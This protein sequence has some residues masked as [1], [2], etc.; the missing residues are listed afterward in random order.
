MAVLQLNGISKAYAGE[1]ILNDITFSVDEKD[2]IGLIGL[3]GAGKTTIIKIILGEIEHDISQ[4]NKIKGNISFKSN[5]NIG[6]LSQNFDLNEENEIYTEMLHVFK[7]TLNIYER[8]KELNIEVS[9]ET[10]EVLDRKLKELAELSSRYEQAEGYSIEY[11]IKQVLIGLGI[12]E[13][14]YKK[15]IKNLSGGQKSRVSL[16]KI[17]L[18]EPDLLILDEPTNHLDIKAIEWLETFLKN[19]NK[20]FILISHDRYFLDNVINRVLEIEAKKIKSYSGNYTQFVIQKELIKRGEIKSF[21]KEQEKV[22]KMEEFIR[23]YK[24]GVKAKQARGRQKLLDRMDLMD[25]PDIKNQKIKLKFETDLLSTNNILTIENLSKQYEEK[26]IFSNVNLNVYRGDRIGFVGKN[27]AG[28]STLLKI[29]AEKIEKTSGNILYGGKLKTAYYDQEHE[30]LDKNMTILEELRNNY[31]LSEEEARSIAGRFLFTEDDIFKKISQLSGGERARISF[32]KLILEKPNFIILDEPTN[33]L[34]IY[35]R[36]ILENAIDDYEGT[37]LIVSHDR[38]FLDRIVDTVYEVSKMGLIKHKNIESYKLE[39][40]SK[41]TE[42]KKEKIIDYEEQKRI[43][44]RIN[45]IEKKYKQLEKEIEN[46]EKNKKEI[47]ERYEYAGKNNNYEDLIIYQNQLEECDENI[48]EK[49]QEMEDIENEL[50][51]LKKE[52]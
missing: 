43:K 11:K 30:N 39:T 24:A 36:E 19:Y 14:D 8:I 7:D 2:K 23:R 15:Q 20:S 38:Y 51:T 34:D 29:I 1:Y 50:E 10:G 6:Y 40:N 32:I 9:Y 44:N 27:G 26:I 35:S 18:Q 5:I 47:E 22:K 17:L 37:L 49:M 31:P 42:D 13:L 21:E 25:D 3:N 12:E 16:G 45:N 33:H 52:Q 28:K 48:I 46:I 41:E 4:L